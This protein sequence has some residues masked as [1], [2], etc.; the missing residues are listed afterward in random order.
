MVNNYTNFN[1]NLS[2]QFTQ[3]KTMSFG[4]GNTCLGLGQ[5]QSCHGMRTLLV[6]GSPTADA[7]VNHV[8]IYLTT[9]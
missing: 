9:S 8:P 1:N 5:A 6:G 7:D 3:Q 4:K 2:P